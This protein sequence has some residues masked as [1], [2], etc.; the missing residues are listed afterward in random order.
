MEWVLQYE[1]GEFATEHLPDAVVNQLPFLTEVTSYLIAN[2]E[3][4][5]ETTL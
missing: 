5:G 3:I 4:I 2:I 1:R